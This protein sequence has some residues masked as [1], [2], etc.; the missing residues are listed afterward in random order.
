M[1]IDHT[2]GLSRKARIYIRARDD[3]YWASIDSLRLEEVA[4]LFASRERLCLQLSRCA[5][6]VFHPLQRWN[7]VSHI[8][9]LCGRYTSCSRIP[10]PGFINEFR[11]VGI[12]RIKTTIFSSER[13][14]LS[15]RE[16]FKFSLVHQ[17]LWVAKIWSLRL[18]VNGKILQSSSNVTYWIN[19]ISTVIDIRRPQA[20]ECPS[21]LQESVMFAVR[22]CSVGAQFLS[23][24]DVQRTD[25]I[26]F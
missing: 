14:M 23:P 21:E 16:V 25:S 20:L 19:C 10:V 9:S 5:C 13:L 18:F 6:H 7:F 8:L 24:S 1:S 3:K 22:G 11:R 12:L 15:C 26:C 17:G 4:S 2:I